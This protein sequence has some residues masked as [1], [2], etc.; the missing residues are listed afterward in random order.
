MGTAARR[1]ETREH[2]VSIGLR[3]F[4]RG[5]V[6]ILRLLPRRA[7]TAR[8]Q[9]AAAATRAR[10]KLRTGMVRITARSVLVAPLL[11]ARLSE[12]GARFAILIGVNDSEDFRMRFGI[13][14]KA[15]CRELGNGDPLARFRIGASHLLQERMAAG[16]RC[17]I[18]RGVFD[19]IAIPSSCE[20]A[21]ILPLG[22]TFRFSF[23]ENRSTAVQRTARARTGWG[24]ICPIGNATDDLLVITVP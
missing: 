17:R 21:A 13:E 23:C 1:L 9:A 18:R 2:P 6:I 14:W 7:A 24:D 8:A 5:E 20:L 10:T 12:W 3:C 4:G 15:A 11:C 19:S 22:R 16:K